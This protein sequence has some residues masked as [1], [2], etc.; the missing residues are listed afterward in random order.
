MAISGFTL[1]YSVPP[2]AS[3]VSLT[4]L[5]T[6]MF[7]LL[8]TPLLLSATAVVLLQPARNTILVIIANAIAET[9]LF[10]ILFILLY[11]KLFW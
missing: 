10:F 7:S 1:R 8:L 3:E 9:N 2:E 4:L 11:I 5:L 6:P